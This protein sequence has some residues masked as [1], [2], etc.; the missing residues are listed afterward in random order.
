MSVVMPALAMLVIFLIAP[1]RVPYWRSIFES[2]SERRLKSLLF[3]LLIGPLWYSFEVSRC[4]FAIWVRGIDGPAIV[5]S[6]YTI[7]I[8]L[9][10]GVIFFLF[11]LRYRCIYGLTEAFLGTWIAGYRAYRTDLPQ[12]DLEFYIA[13]LTAGVYLVVRG[14]DN[15]Q[16]GL[17]QT[18]PDPLA[19]I[20]LSRFKL[21]TAQA[22]GPP[23]VTEKASA[24]VDNGARID[25]GGPAVSK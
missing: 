12:Q 20:I 5:R 21:R 3:V 2:L 11:R 16:Q 23:S 22:E 18:T 13:M 1:P 4:D 8:A 10:L 9:G 24:A 19:T 6:N 25:G 15:M 7:L 17:T 14:L